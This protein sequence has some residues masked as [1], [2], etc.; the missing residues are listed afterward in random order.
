MDKG[1]LSNGLNDIIQSINDVNQE[2]MGMMI[3]SDVPTLEK[4][5]LNSEYNLQ[6]YQEIDEAFN[7]VIQAVNVLVNISWK[8][9]VADIMTG[10]IIKKIKPLL[11]NDIQE[12]SVA[13]FL[14]DKLLEIQNKFN[15][16]NELFIVYGYIQERK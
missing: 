13:I 7:F 4:I 10:E 5:T 14:N 11:M 12:S 15:E 3:I 6:A 8:L 2:L 1:R 9:N 16:V